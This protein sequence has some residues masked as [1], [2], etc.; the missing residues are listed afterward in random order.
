MP[1]KDKYTDPDLR[2]EIKQE[3]QESDKGGAPGQWSARKAQ[4]MASEY[5]KRG[6]GYN[7]DKS[8]QDE[9]QKHLSKWTEEEWQTKEGSGNAK[10]ADGTEKRYLPKKAW[11]NMTEE[12]KEETEQKKQEGS[13]EGKQFVQNTA[14]AQQ[15]RRQANEEEDEKYEKKKAQ[16]QQSKQNEQD[17]A[18]ND[19]DEHAAE[20][21]DDDSDDEEEDNE[22]EDF[23]DDGEDAEGEDGEDGRDD[24]DNDEED[25]EV[26]EDGDAE[27]KTGQKRKGGAD[28]QSNGKSKKQKSERSQGNAPAG[29]VGSKHMDADEPAPRGSADRLPKKG[30]KITWK[31]MPGYVDGEVTEVLTSGKKVD[32]KD[33][34]ASKKDPKLVMKSSS[35]G[36]VCVHKPDACFYD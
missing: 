35:S 31:A 16:E 5:K 17:Q 10:Q 18:G 22:A 26:D 29:K 7:T 9:S 34:K 6:G 4:F 27:A 36:K 20:E 30:Q 3:V 32:G 11:E 28:N 23:E 15:S 1:P 25:E 24:N 2:D 19:E 8:Q 21:Y 12:E 13:R 14:K 33:V